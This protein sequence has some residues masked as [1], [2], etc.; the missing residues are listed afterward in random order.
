MTKSGCFDNH[1]SLSGRGA[2]LLEL[3]LHLVASG[4]KRQPGLCG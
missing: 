3:D 4:L 1:Q 2:K